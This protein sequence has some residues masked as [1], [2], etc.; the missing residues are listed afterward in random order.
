MAWLHFVYSLAAPDSLPGRVS[1][2]GALLDAY[3]SQHLGHSWVQ[4]RSS[5]RDANNTEMNK[6]DTNLS[7]KKRTEVVCPF[8]VLV[9]SLSSATEGAGVAQISDSLRIEGSQELRPRCQAQWHIL[10]YGDDA[11]SHV[12]S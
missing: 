3:L 6:T 7:K 5:C 1:S 2:L 12:L 10:G 4:R 11:G 8:P 9:I